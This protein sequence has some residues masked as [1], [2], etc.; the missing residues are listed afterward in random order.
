MKRNECIDFLKG[1]TIFLVVLGHATQWFSG[2]DAS[3]RLFIFIYSFHMPLFMFLSGFVSFNA[4][5]EV[6]IWKRFQGLVIP[7]LVWFFIQKY[8]DYQWNIFSLEVFAQQFK[9]LLVTPTLGRW[10]LWILFWLC[11]LL[12]ISLKISI[13]RE[14]IILLGIIL[15][16][17]LLTFSEP[18]YGFLEI[19]WY[20]FFFILGYSFH[21]Y[22]EKCEAIL[23]K[24]ALVS[25]PIF[26]GLFSLMKA[27]SQ[28]HFLDDVL[29]PTS[30]K[31]AIYGIATFLVPMAAIFSIYFVFSKINAYDFRLKKVFIFLGTISL[32]IY[33]THYYFHFL[34]KYINMY[35]TD[36]MYIKIFIFTSLAIIGSVFVQKIIK[37][38]AFLNR[39]LYGKFIS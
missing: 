20:A 29:M 13:K 19:K 9:S 7:F 17:S 35:I 3:N 4:R 26:L 10:F 6:K 24:L 34:T 15:F 2:Y 31:N 30:V 27:Q 39:I 37:K 14:E 1:F 18:K 33:V 38:I 16:F 32:E 21:K 28:F 25:F 5:R 11:V 8:I 12:F 36:F 22:K 23:P